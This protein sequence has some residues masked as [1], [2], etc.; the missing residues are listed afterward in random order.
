[1]NSVTALN[2]FASIDIPGWAYGLAVGWIGEETDFE[3]A[4]TP[5][6]L[7]ADLEVLAADAQ[8]IQ[9]G[10]HYCWCDAESPLRSRSELGDEVVQ[11]TG[12]IWVPDGDVCFASP[13][14]IVH[15]VAE[16]RYR[17]PARFVE[18]VARAA[19]LRRSTRPNGE[20]LAE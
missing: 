19:D 10:L 15:Y 7:I 2:D 20:A 17:P 8:R 18:A 6:G 13:T 11:G 16:H 5:P 4:E 12:E 9:R 3:P 14:L 1:V